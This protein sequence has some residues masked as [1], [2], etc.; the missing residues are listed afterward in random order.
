MQSTLL[1][2]K[3]INTDNE[4]PGF[5]GNWFFVE[6][7]RGVQALKCILR[8]PLTLKPILHNKSVNRET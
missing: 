6:I 5:F 3:I 4:N 8:K 7:R 2:S 1:Q